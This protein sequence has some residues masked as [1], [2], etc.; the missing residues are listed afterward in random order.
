[1]KYG[2]MVHLFGTPFIPKR[3]A[4]QFCPDSNYLMFEFD[5]VYTKEFQYLYY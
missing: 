2:W 3:M 5:R 1:M 4:F